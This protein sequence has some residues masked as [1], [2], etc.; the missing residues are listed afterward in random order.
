MR[1]MAVCT[2]LLRERQVNECFLTLGGDLWVAFLAKR[3]RLLFQQRRESRDV[4]VMTRD[5]VAIRE[6]LVLE[7]LL[8]LLIQIVALRADILRNQ[9]ATGR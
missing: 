9:G 7:A 4:G 5:A 8:S 1:I 3:P 2:S 6:R